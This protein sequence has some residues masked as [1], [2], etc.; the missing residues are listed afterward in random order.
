[1]QISFLTC[2][3]GTP[4]SSDFCYSDHLHS[5]AASRVVSP[6][7]DAA[8]K[9]GGQGHVTPLLHAT[10]KAKVPAAWDMR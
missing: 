3:P 7:D 9:M 2:S 4:V 5:E 10:Q 6:D 1:M 8:Q